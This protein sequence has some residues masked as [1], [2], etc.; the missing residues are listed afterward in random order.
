MLFVMLGSSSQRGLPGM[1]PIASLHA[2]SYGCFVD[3]E[4]YVLDVDLAT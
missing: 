1:F 4:S 2:L 3:S